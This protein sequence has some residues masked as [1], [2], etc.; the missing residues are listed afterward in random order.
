MTTDPKDHAHRLK[1]VFRILAVLAERKVFGE[2]F[3]QAC[4]S[5][6]SCALY[7]PE[8]EELTMMRAVNSAF[9][10]AIKACYAAGIDPET[11]Q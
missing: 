7:H 3:A 11:I 9:V 4:E 6:S 5:A 10:L 8:F 1:R 2:E